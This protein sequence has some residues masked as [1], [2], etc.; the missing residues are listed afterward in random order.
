M[1]QSYRIPADYSDDAEELMLSEPDTGSKSEEA[2]CSDL[3]YK[4]LEKSLSKN[5][6]E[7]NASTK[8]QKFVDVDSEC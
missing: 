5:F 7:D 2:V 3:Y 4:R 1:L 8:P 6:D